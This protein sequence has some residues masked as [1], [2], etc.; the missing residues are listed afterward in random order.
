MTRQNLST[1]DLPAARPSG[2]FRA[3]RALRVLH[4]LCAALL[5]LLAGGAAPP[6]HAQT[7]DPEADSPPRAESAPASQTPDASTGSLAGQV[8]T[9][10]G[11]AVAD[12][13]VRIVDLRRRG[14]T[15]PDGT[16]RFTGLRPGSY[17]V[18]A[19][20]ASLGGGS[21]RVQVR[22]GRE[23]VATVLIDVVILQDE[24][25]VSAGAAPRRQL[26]VAQPVTVL[27]GEEL[28]QNREATLGETLAREPGVSSTYFGPGA[29]RPV[30]RGLGGDRVRMLSDGLG[31]ADASNLSPDHAV[32]IE[33]QNA[34]RIEVLRG[35]ATLL[36]G[37][38]AVGGVVNVL[39]SRIPRYLPEEPV[40]G[41]L[42]LSY[43]SAADER[44]GAVELVG[45]S[46]RVAWHG[47]YSRRETDDVEIPG[48]AALDPAERAEQRR[49]VLANSALDNES[50]SAGLTW[51]RESFNVGLS[52]SGFD[53]L[54]GI[55]GGHGE[56]EE[57]VRVD[58]EQRRYDF[59]AEVN[60]PFGLF[61]GAKLRLG[62]ADYEHRELEGTAV[63]TRFLDDSWESRLELVQK[64]R[65]GWRGSVGVQLAASDF[66]ALGDEAF[67]PPSETT[68]GAL[69]AFQELALGGSREAADGEQSGGERWLLQLGGRLERQEIDVTGNLPDR[70]S[71]GFSTSAGIVFQPGA[72][73]SAALSLAR[74]ERLPTSTE[75][76]ANGPHAA[77]RTFEIGSPDL[78]KETSLGVD[79]SLHK[80]T[81]R[82]TGTLNLFANRFDQYVFE[83]F[84]GAVEDGLDV[85]V[86][87]Q[88]DA[89]FAGA[90]LQ[91]LV[92]L[93]QTA[94]GLHMDLT[95]GGDYVR[96]R[97]ADSGEPLPRI[98]PM[99]GNLGLSLHRDRLRAYA[100]VYRA[101]RQ[102]R[103]ADFETPT[104]GYT[105]L[106]AG[107][108]YRLFV[109][110]RVLD[111]SLRG[112]NLTN[113][114]ARNHV[115]FLKDD[116]TLPGRD[117]SLGVRL[118]F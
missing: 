68:S 31:S 10:A 19:E 95:F 49:G 87:D 105:L 85:V 72:G 75:L 18:E 91:G 24:V 36:Y 63:G 109:A 58:L 44:A 5:L 52:Y 28:D 23:T 103:T 118:A 47:A 102:S 106:S 114:E 15:G 65:S 80:R 86:F 39:D 4:G 2:V 29:S 117:L 104:D 8:I 99:S 3:L 35:P 54:Y 40:S 45:G 89:E 60:R 48:Y 113:E 90:E 108:S 101:Q 107:V 51:I 69:F 83:R 61:Q 77:T 66:S 76:Y 115:S 79:L 64:E 112:R 6:A 59:R 74:S 98:P 56:E 26:E 9:T 73:Y 71:D 81:G 92:S 57:A 38:T 96:A 67:V 1:S 88:Q 82:V 17:V 50:A 33:P 93:L 116:V 34:E 22:A 41:T 78:D 11:E 70:S 110:G 32:S 94:G 100:E 43:G 30:I 25:V 21:D 16:F 7:A 84:N 12:A 27:S 53:S 97:L 20:S 111:L 37:S 62:S 42:D 14:R 55:P 13:E 46:G